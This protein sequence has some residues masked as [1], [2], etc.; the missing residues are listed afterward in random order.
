MIRWGRN[1]KKILLGCL[2]MFALSVFIET[3]FNSTGAMTVRRGEWGPMKN[4]QARVLGWDNSCKFG[5]GAPE[6]AKYVKVY[7]EYK[8]EGNEPVI[9]DDFNSY[10]KL[11]GKYHA[12]SFWCDEFFPLSELYPGVVKTVHIGFEVPISFVEKDAYI[13][14]D[15]IRWNIE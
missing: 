6:G 3:K 15:G 4:V 5:G 10:M 7:L 1:G 8:I 13:L 11:N 9:V 12:K 14:L 2:V